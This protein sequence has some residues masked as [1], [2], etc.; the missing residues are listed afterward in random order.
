MV[1]GVYRV[2]LIVHGSHSLKDKRQVIKK[3][4]GGVKNRYN[5]SISEVS[6]ND[7]WQRAVL[8]ITAVGND[9]AYVNSLLDKVVGF[10]DHMHLAEIVDQEIELINC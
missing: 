6:A 8:G 3:L 5:V 1:V 9:R 4:I 7:L 10:I 2:T